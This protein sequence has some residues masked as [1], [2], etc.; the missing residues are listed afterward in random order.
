MNDIPVD[1]IEDVVQD[2][3]VSYARYKYSLDMSEESKRA[4][5]IR[6]LKSRC[7]DFHRRM[8]YRSYGEL[9]EEAYNSEDY[10]A[11]DKAANLPDYVVSKER[12]QALLKEIE[13]TADKGS[14]RYVGYYR[15]GMLFQSQPYQEVPR[16]TAKK[17]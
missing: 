3:F 11:H 7:M 14:M 5:L 6:I 16:R 9:D 1:Y 13:R 10:P 15:K 8:K 4:L 2:T 17:R 12:C